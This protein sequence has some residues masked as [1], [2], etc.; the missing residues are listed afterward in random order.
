MQTKREN[1]G[2]NVSRNLDAMRSILLRQLVRAPRQSFISPKDW[3][4]NKI[5][6][7]LSWHQSEAKQIAHQSELNS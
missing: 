2:K 4:K 6:S 1:R 7:Q 3:T 5:A